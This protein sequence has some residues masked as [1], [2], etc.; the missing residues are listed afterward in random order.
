MEK[1]L[2]AEMSTIIEEGE[3]TGGEL[4]RISRIFHNRVEDQRL[5]LLSPVI[6]KKGNPISVVRHNSIEEIS[7]R[8]SRMHIRRRT[9]RSQTEREMSMFGALTAVLS[10]MENRYYIDRVLSGIDFLKGFY[11]ITKDELNKAKKLIRP[12]PENRSYARMRTG[13][14][15]LPPL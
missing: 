12:T 14:P 8:W 7:H 15:F 2:N 9:E 1:D 3:F 13:S 6:V 4:E 10:N 5:V 11:S